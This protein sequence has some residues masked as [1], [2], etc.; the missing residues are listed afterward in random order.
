MTT[1]RRTF[2]L[3]LLVLGALPAASPAATVSLTDGQARFAADP[4][5]KNDVIVTNTD[6]EIVFEDQGT[7]RDLRAGSACVLHKPA[8]APPSVH[9]PRTDATRVVAELG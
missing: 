9:C 4:G 5:E 8:E 2:L 1:F 6:T 3:A 7:T